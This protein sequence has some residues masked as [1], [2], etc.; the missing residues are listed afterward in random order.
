[1]ALSYCALMNASLLCLTPS[2]AYVQ[3]VLGTSWRTNTYKR[4]IARTGDL[5]D[6]L[7]GEM[8]DEKSLFII[9]GYYR[10]A[11]AYG[12]RPGSIFANSFSCPL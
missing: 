5:V 12:L 1:M 8:G 11:M 4:A 10:E 7:L 2:A 3:D 9:T 6:A